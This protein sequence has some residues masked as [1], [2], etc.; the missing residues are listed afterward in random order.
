LEGSIVSHGNYLWKFAMDGAILD[1]KSVEERTE[2][3]GYVNKRFA[4]WLNEMK[5]DVGEKYGQVVG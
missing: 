4:D 1:G 2:I 5:K 3:L